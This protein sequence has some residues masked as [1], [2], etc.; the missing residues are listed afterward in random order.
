MAYARKQA[1]LCELKDLKMV[2]A[3]EHLTEI[4][5]RALLSP[6]FPEPPIFYSSS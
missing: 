1:K 3:V 6:L 5:V 4:I 2:D